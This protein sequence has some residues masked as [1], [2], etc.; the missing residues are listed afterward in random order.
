M[1]TNGDVRKEKSMFR[2]AK[3]AATGYV[4][5]HTEDLPLAVLGRISLAGGG[6]GIIKGIAENA[7]ASR[8][9]LPLG[10]IAVGSALHCITHPE[11][12]QDT[13]SVVQDNAN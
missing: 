4:N 6:A 10:L 3:E 13:N 8:G 11:S 12:N 5:R 1:N 2:K 9:L 7:P